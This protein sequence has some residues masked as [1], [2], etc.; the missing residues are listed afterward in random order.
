VEDRSV[1]LLEIALSAIISWASRQDVRDETMRRARC[2]LPPAHAWLLGRVSSFG[3]IRIGALAVALGLDNSTI[4]PQ[5]QRLEREG[6]ISREPDPLDRRAALVQITAPG[7]RVLGRLQRSRQALLFEKLRDWPTADRET[8]AAIVA[9]LA[10][11]L[12]P[13]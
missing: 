4:T 11:A 7:E 3:P 13:A 1:L 5:L 12:G 8:V 2:S 6:L 10:N 9:R